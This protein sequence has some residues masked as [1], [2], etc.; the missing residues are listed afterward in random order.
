MYS[1]KDDYSEGCHPAI[2]EAL[3]RTNLIQQE[4][5]GE[6]VYSKEAKKLIREKIQNPD[7]EIFL[8]SGGTQTNLIVIASALKPHESVICADTGHI[9]LHEAGAIEAVGHKINEIKSI[10]GKISPIKIQTLLDEHNVIPHMV[11]PKMVYI[12]NAT[13]IGSIYSKQEPMSFS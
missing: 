2:L 5:Y 11:K 12:S 10:D 6:D 3:T 7:A 9:N 8:V 4:G 13:E 1:F